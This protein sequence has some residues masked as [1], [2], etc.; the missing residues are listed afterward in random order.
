MEIGSLAFSTDGRL[1]LA[2]VAGNTDPW[3]RAILLPLRDQKLGS[4]LWQLFRSSMTISD[5]PFGEN[6]ET[7]AFVGDDGKLRI[8][9]LTPGVPGK[10]VDG[11]HKNATVAAFAPLLRERL[12]VGSSNGTIYIYQVRGGMQSATAIMALRGHTAPVT[13]LRFNDNGTKLLSADA[14]GE[15]RLW[16]LTT[17]PLPESTDD[18]LALVD[19]RLP[20][21]LTVAE[22]KA[23]LAK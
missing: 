3:P 10:I 5:S 4:P 21:N 11:P 9:P 16:D 20:S 12:A 6:D 18:L 23:L 1:L 19:D 8:W 22:Q 14:N 7:I 17:T 2:V 13:R 15:V